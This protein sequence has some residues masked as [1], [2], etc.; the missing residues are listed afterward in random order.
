MLEM[1]MQWTSMS[2]QFWDENPSEGT[3]RVVVTSSFDEY[4][5]G[6]QMSRSNN[7]DNNIC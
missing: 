6:I 5:L 3:W 2:V 4:V 1:T 7:Y